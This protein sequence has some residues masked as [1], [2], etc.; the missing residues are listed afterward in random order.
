MA[1]LQV[2][3]SAAAFAEWN[4]LNLQGLYLY[5]TPLGT[6]ANQAQVIDTAPIGIGAT[7]VNNWA[8]YDGAGPDATL[9][10]R[11]Q[12]LHIQA[13]NWVNSFSLVFENER[14]S[15]S[16]LEVMGITVETGEWA[17]VGG[18]GQFAMANGVISKKFHEQRSDGN[19]IELSVRAFCPVLKETRYA[20]TKI[21]PWGGMGGSPM[22]LTEASKR[23]ESITVCSGMVVDSIAFS[24]VDFS[25]QKR[26]AGPWGGSGGNPETI[27][28]AESEVVTEVSGTVGNFYDN[29]VITS[30]KFV[31][32]LQ[33]YGPWGDGQDAPFTIPVQPGSGIV[34]F[35]ARAGDCLD[36]IG[37]YALS[38]TARRP[39]LSFVLQA[40]DEELPPIKGSMEAKVVMRNSHMQPC[41]QHRILTR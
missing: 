9:V 38:S 11:A 18:T 17:V 1:N 20:V 22:D 5:H 7:V 36:A 3:P 21:G 2:T 40:R 4:E 6:E 16:T 28:L 30:I 24:Y 37:V 12:G 23:L 10:A 32:N 31:T 29:T 14:F 19:I 25:G 26:S 15:G 8:V 13:G 39:A 41:L 35:F 27:Q 33:T 34:G